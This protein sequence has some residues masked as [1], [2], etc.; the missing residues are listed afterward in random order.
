MA[1]Q[2]PFDSSL[3]PRV[4]ASTP[5]GLPVLRQQTYAQLVE[6]VGGDELLLKLG[7][8][9]SVPTED[10]DTTPAERLANMVFDQRERSRNYLRF[11][12]GV[13][14]EAKSAIKDLFAVRP[15]LVRRLSDTVSAAFITEFGGNL[16]GMRDGKEETRYFEGGMGFALRAYDINSDFDLI[17]RFANLQD[18]DITEIVAVLKGCLPEKGRK[19]TLFE[20]VMTGPTIPEEEDPYL[21]ELG[22]IIGGKGAWAEREAGAVAMQ[23][24][25]KHA[26][27]KLYSTQPPIT[28]PIP[29]TPQAS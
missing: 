6:A 10:Y 24:I 2:K 11:H 14:S 23:K 29:P 9:L 20:E 17:S 13:N 3:P 7:L 22:K 1:E 27:P 5:S 25:L 28:A 21:Y 26:W 19:L 12:E 16:N 15:D 8:K 18:A 4:E